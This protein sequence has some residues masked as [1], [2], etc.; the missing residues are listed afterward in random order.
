[1][2]QGWGLPRDDILLMWLWATG[3]PNKNELDTGLTFCYMVDD[4][5]FPE[6]SNIWKRS[7]TLK[8]EN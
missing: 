3:S 5:C 2:D 8:R 7:E 6:G 4:L 1:M